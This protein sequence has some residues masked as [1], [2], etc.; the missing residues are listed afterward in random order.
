MSD[1]TLNIEQYSALVTLARR[2]CENPEQARTL[3]SYLKEIDKQ[4]HVT[5]Y[6]LLIQWQELDSPVPPTARFPEKWPPELRLF[7]ERIDRPIAKSD[8]TS[9]VAKHA[10]NPH[11]VM[12]TRDVAGLVGWTKLDDFFIT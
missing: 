7:M 6:S 11:E 12:V 2:G 9:A 5:R 4:N 3:E 8:V 1:V 10:K